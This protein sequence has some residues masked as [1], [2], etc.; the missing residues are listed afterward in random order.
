M[1]HDYENV[2][3]G[4]YSSDKKYKNTQ[5]YRIFFISYHYHPPPNPYIRIPSATNKEACYSDYELRQGAVE[6]IG[7]PRQQ[8]FQIVDIFI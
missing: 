3:F 2:E 6:A 4:E 1:N 7:R 8:I 5:K